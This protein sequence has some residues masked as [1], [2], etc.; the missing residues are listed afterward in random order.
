MHTAVRNDKRFRR[1]RIPPPA[2][3]LC[4]DSSPQETQEVPLL[5]RRGVLKG[6][7]R[8]ALGVS[9]GL[10]GFRVPRAIAQSVD[11]VVDLGDGLYIVGTGQTN[12]LAAV[13]D[14]GVALVDGGAADESAELLRRV[15]DLPGAGPVHSLLNTHWHPDHTG[16]NEPL[17]RAG[18]RIVAQV[19]TKQWLSTDV[20]WPWN[21]ETIAPLP[22]PARPSETFYD[23]VELTLAGRRVVCAH[24][25]DCPHTDGD[26]Y[27][28]FPDQNVMAIGDAISGAGWPSIDWWTGGWVGGIVGALDMILTATDAETIFVPSRGPALTREDLLEQYVMYGTI[29]QRLLRVLYAG[30]GP[31]EALEAEPTKEFN[32]LMGPSDEFVVRA[33]ESMWPNLSPDA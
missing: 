21:D 23:A 11:G 17:A 25:K 31:K 7:L 2:V 19:N 27:V 9:L 32:D 4:G 18:A 20:T 33:L 16:S 30:G 5:S 10:A 14:G 24:L 15:A 1:W 26:M 6:A 22:E 12:V 8:S 28:Y 29:W 3:K 13:A